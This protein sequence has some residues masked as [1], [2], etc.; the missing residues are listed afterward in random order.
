MD[1]LLPIMID[2]LDD[3]IEAT[4][5]AFAALDRLY[6]LNGECM[7]RLAMEEPQITADQLQELCD[8][9]NFEQL[10]IDAWLEEHKNVCNVCDEKLQSIIMHPDVYRVVENYNNQTPIQ[11]FFQNLKWG[12]DYFSNN[13]RNW[14]GHMK[15]EDWDFWE[16]LS[17]EETGYE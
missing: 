11:R 16:I 10:I 5:N 4:E 12:F 17:G 1:T 9:M 13:F 15:G 3:K 14:K 6:D 8:D 2:P 7:R